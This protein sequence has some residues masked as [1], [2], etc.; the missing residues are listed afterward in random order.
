M[1]VYINSQ[2]HMTKMTAMA[3]IAKPFKNLIFFSRTRMP[4][5]LKPGMK[6]QGEELYKV[7][8]NHGPGMTLTYLMA[9][10][11]EGAHAFK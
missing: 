9:R 10:S 5:I 6:H 3:I 8:V 4:T 2:G 7:Y 11:T 1:K